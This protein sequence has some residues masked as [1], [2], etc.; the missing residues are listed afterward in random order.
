MDKPK[1][2]TWWSNNSWGIM[3]RRINKIVWTIWSWPS[4]VTTTRNTPQPGPPRS[5]WWRASH[6]L[7]PWLGQHKDNLQV[8][9]VKR[10]Q[11]SRNLMKRESAC[12]SWKRPTWKRRTKDT[13][14]QVPGW[15]HLKV[16]QSVVAESWDSEGAPDFQHYKGVEGRARS[17]GIRLGRRFSRSSLNLHQNKSPK[18]SVHISGH[19]GVLRQA[20]ALWTTRHTTA[21]T[22]GKPPPSPI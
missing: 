21:R 2:S 8:M 17:L 7:C 19:P 22:R 15:T 13:H 5:K 18:W 4:F 1:G 12:G 9:Q 14:S 10:C 3:W 11:W 16:H 20:Q 6:Q